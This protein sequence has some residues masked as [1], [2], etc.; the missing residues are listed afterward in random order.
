MCFQ[1]DVYRN[2]SEKTNT[3]QPYL[4]VIQHDYYD[5]LN[6]RLIVPLSYRKHLTRYF[7]QATP[8]V[9]IEFQTLFLNTPGITSVDKKRLSS[10]YFVC[11]LQ[12]ARQDVVAALDALITNT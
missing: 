5:D 1:F 9:N 7:H 12:T 11:N 10:R 3:L 6:T 2:P 8:L 4:M